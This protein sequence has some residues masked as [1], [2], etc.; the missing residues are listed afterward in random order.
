M[1]Q[2]CTFY[3]DDDGKKK[4]ELVLVPAH[5]NGRSSFGDYRQLDYEVAIDIEPLISGKQEIAAAH[6][7]LLEEL[8]RPSSS[9]FPIGMNSPHPPSNTDTPETT[10]Q[11]LHHPTQGLPFV[12]ADSSFQ[13]QSMLN[14]ESNMP[15]ELKP[16]RAS[17]SVSK[18]KWSVDK[19]SDDYK[20]RRE[21]NNLAVKKSR[22]KS[23]QRSQET[24]Q[25][26]QELVTEN[27]SLRSNIDMLN[28]E[29]DVLK[30]LFSSHKDDGTV[31][32]TTSHSS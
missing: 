19:N 18:R 7:A 21:R 2:N 17:G 13:T 24:E 10:F 1:A 12:S 16:K 4:E 11:V 31:S 30:A 20:K 3:Q 28:K 9:R 14:F 6:P 5:C 26:V 25:R 8:L 23:R 15:S 32:F 29:L 27:K 22:E